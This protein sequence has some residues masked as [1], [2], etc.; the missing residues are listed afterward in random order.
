MDV[1]EK[2]GC[3]RLSLFNVTP[4]EGSLESMHGYVSLSAHSGPVTEPH[5]LYCVAL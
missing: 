2:T 4:P 1:K 3:Q 5:L